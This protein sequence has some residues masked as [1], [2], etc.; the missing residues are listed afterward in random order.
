MTMSLENA[1]NILQ[2]IYSLFLKLKKIRIK[3]YFIDTKNY[4]YASAQKLVPYLMVNHER[5]VH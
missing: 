5:H 2:S 1:W 4:T 3:W